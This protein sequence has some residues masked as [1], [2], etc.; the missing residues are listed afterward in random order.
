MI[1]ERLASALASGPSDRPRL[2]YAFLSYHRRANRVGYNAGKIKASS[3]PIVYS[4]SR[5]LRDVLMLTLA[6]SALAMSQAAPPA[7]SAAQVA[8]Q[9]G[10][11]AIKNRDLTRARA[12]FERAVRLAPNDGQAQSALG[13][14]LAQQG[15]LD[16]AA[17]HLKAAIKSKPGFADARLTLASVLV[18]QGKAAQAEGEVR[19]ALKASPENAEAHRQLG[20]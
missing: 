18:R 8:L 19:A 16:Q 7:K 13:W 6:A 3:T 17:S 4:I 12:E 10:Q 14:V 15:E 11:E 2:S 9:R 20:R 1:A 5:I